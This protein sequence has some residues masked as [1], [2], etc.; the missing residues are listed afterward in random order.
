[1]VQERR[2][3]SQV[4]VERVGSGA[5]YA[6]VSTVGAPGTRAFVLVPGIGV[7]SN[8]F[9]RLAGRLNELGP[10]VALDLPGFGGVPHP[11]H[12]MTMGEYADLVGDVIDQLGLE[13]PVLVGHS[14]G[15]QVVAALAAHRDLTDVVLISPIVNPHERRLRTVL[16]RF[17]SSSLHEPPRVVALALYAYALCGVRWIFRVLPE[18]LRFR[19]EDV[20]PHVRANTLVVFGEEDRLVPSSW[21]GEVGRLLPHGQVWQVPGAA[22]SVMHRNAEDVARLCVAHVRREDPD[23]DRVHRLRHDDGEEPR[24]DLRT[25]LAEARGGV[26]ELVGILTHDDDLIARG[27]TEHAEAADRVAAEASEDGSRLD[28]QQPE[29]EPPTS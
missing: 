16:L 28:E 5:V 10:V 24:P 4:H 2:R 8:Y 3:R 22:H 11:P 21:A 1:M 29:Q 26:T 12:P 20:L 7:M 27:K 6:R 25:R 19:L 13:D 9:E 18:V 23:D 15:V 14:M 17:V